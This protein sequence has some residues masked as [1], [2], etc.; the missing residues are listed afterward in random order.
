VSNQADKSA[1]I[2]GYFS[3]EI[4]INEKIPSYSGG[5]GVLA[6][7]TIKSFADMAVPVVAVTL[8]SGKGYFKQ[9]I[10]NGEQIEHTVDWNPGSLLE[11]TEKRVVIKLENRKVNIRSWQLIV[12]GSTGFNVPVIFL[13]TNVPENYEQD[14]H[15]TDFLYGG[16]NIYR[17]KQEAVLGIGGFRM[18]EALGYTNIR[19]YHL[20]EGHAAFLVIELLKRYHNPLAVDVNKRYDISSVKEKCVFTTHTP[21]PAG[22]D[23][24]N[25]EDIYSIL[26]EDI[27]EKDYLL[28]FCHEDKLNMTL[29]ALSN[30][31]YINGVAETHKEVSRS[32]FPG[33]AID[34]ITNGVHSDTWTCNEFKS[35]YD[36]HIPGWRIDPFHL[37]YALSISRK[38]IWEAHL[39]AKKKLID[40][41]NSVSKLG[42]EYDVFTLGFARRSTQYK[43]L[44]LLFMDL[45]ELRSINKQTKLQ[46]IMA[47]KAH[48]KDAGG[49]EI[50][51]KLHNLITE[52]K[53]DIKIV[54][55]ADYNI[56]CA[57]IIVSGVDVWLNT[58][59]RPL[60]ASGTSGMK[61][62]HNAVPNLSIL[63]GWWVEGHVENVTGWSIGKKNTDPSQTEEEIDKEDA[64]DLYI[65]LKEIVLPMFYNDWDKW[66]EIMRHSVAFNAS[67][68]NT[69][70]MV[71]QYVLNSYF[72]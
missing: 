68:F 53:D 47:G 29:L 12:N 62:S 31:K 34:S 54:Y 72:H 49:K 26:G 36:N 18:L 33:Y 70:R 40:Y 19:K 6:G 65:K 45:V 50:I 57:K 58:P 20:N 60:E 67:F 51:K 46:I 55:L 9:E 10:K 56:G 66:T 21:V 42:F 17:I 25:I 3:M 15:I 7:D 39:A 30:A 32:M 43:R 64:L 28:K 63:D 5:L 8:L 1:R 38:E 69:H 24:F 48:P 59:R 61:A 35:L 52:L 14:R 13:D 71:Y 37:R 41:V 22:H 4:G 44:D 23:Q 16:D 2:I 11:L 27:L